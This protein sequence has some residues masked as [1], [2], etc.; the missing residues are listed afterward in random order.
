MSLMIPR[1]GISQQSKGT[2]GTAAAAIGSG[3]CGAVFLIAHEDNTAPVFWGG[4]GLVVDGGPPL[5]PGQSVS[6][7]VAGVEAV[8]VASTDGSQVYY[9]ASLSRT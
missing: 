5:Y 2:A 4:Q 3:E 9:W 6:L 8:Y 7:Y 1:T